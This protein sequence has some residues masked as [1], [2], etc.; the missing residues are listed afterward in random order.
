MI[1][2]SGENIYLAEVEAEL[3]EHSAVADAAVGIPDERCGEACAA[4]VAPAT[5]DELRDHCHGKLAHFT[6][7]K[8]FR[9]IDELA[10]NSMGT[11]R[12][13]ALAS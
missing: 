12:K 6:V 10:R 2:P 9:F 3:H 4:F 13:L 11:I 7:P 8:T 1:A 5:E